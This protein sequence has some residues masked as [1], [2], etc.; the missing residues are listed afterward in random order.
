M[1]LLPL[2]L[3]KQISFL[4]VMGAARR[5]TA[6]LKQRLSNWVVEVIT[7]AYKKALPGSVSCHSTRSV[8]TSWAAFRG[9]SM[10]DICAAATWTSPCTFARFYKLNIATLH[11]VSSA[12]LREKF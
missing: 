7:M 9:V 5:G 6:V 3:E 11:T 2:I 8:L 12:V 10:A 4:C 1:W